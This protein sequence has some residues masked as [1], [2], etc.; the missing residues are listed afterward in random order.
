MRSLSG[1]RHICL[2]RVFEH[3]TSLS[4]SSIPFSEKKV[5][6]NQSDLGEPEKLQTFF[7]YTCLR[8][9]KKT[10]WELFDVFD[11]TALQPTRVSPLKLSWY[12]NQMFVF[13]SRSMG[14]VS[15]HRA[16]KRKE[17]WRQWE[18]VPLARFD[19]I[20]TSFHDP[21]FMGTPLVNTVMSLW[22][23]VLL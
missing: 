14:L 10:F 8:L 17:R 18:C 7:F 16:L 23:Q 1:R 12:G 19:S 11:E 4:L 3:Q 2:V 20:Q 6:C 21:V 5:S 13:P 15:A 22:H 9:E